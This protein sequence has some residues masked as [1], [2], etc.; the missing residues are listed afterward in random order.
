[1]G[2]S[3]SNVALIEIHTHGGESAFRFL[4]IVSPENMMNVPEF[5]QIQLD[6]G[7]ATR[8][9]PT[10]LGEPLSLVAETSVANPV[11]E[12]RRK[13]E[14]STEVLQERVRNALD[15]NEKVRK[16]E[17]ASFTEVDG[18]CEIEPEDVSKQRK[19]DLRARRRELLR[20][21]LDKDFSQPRA[22]TRSQQFVCVTVSVEPTPTIIVHSAHET[23]EQ[24]TQTAQQLLATDRAISIEVLE[25]CKWFAEHEFTDL[26]I[27]GTETTYVDNHGLQPL[28]DNARKNS[29]LT[30]QIGQ[31]A[32][33]LGASL[34]SSENNPQLQ[35]D[36]GH[37]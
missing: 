15:F 30:S 7:V 12:D 32:Q 6:N 34:G 25:S 16:G 8:I 13:F 22:P 10:R 17:P 20:E 5:K 26:D 23:P 14:Q 31:R 3:D 33:D 37:L 2:D 1:M 29:Q 4:R 28:M 21:V 35:I 24:A 36:Q 18:V 19:G 11:E 27:T 9:V